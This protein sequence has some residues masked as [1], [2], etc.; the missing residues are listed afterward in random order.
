VCL[1]RQSPSAVPADI[2]A[3][4]A[5][6]DTGTNSSL[7]KDSIATEVCVLSSYKCPNGKLFMEGA[8]A[9]NLP[10]TTNKD[11]NHGTQMISVITRV[12]SAAKIIPIR[13]VAN[14]SG[15]KYGP[16]HIR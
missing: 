8:G 5:V 3:S 12:N 14:D 10:A 4:I 2:P 7:F 1:R 11:F 13:I 9:A 6:I 15:G 16:I